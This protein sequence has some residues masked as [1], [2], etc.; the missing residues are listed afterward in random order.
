MKKELKVGVTELHGIA[1]ESVKSPPEGISY[2]KLEPKDV[3]SNHI[4]RS[5]AKGVLNRYIDDDVDFVEAPLF[6]ILTSKPWIYTPADTASAMA[7]NIFGVP[8]PRIFRALI[9]R[10]L[11]SRKNFLGLFFKSEAGLK[12]LDEYPLL[13]SKKIRADV[14]YPAVQEYSRSNG[15]QRRDAS[16]INLIFVGEFFRKGGKEVIDAFV[17]LK[18]KY[19]NISLS[20]CADRDKH[21]QSELY[22]EKYLEII[23]S[24]ENINLQ[25]VTREE[26]FDEHFE[27]ADIFLCPTFQESFG[28]AI[29]EAM[30]KGL[31]I[32]ASDVF[33]IPEM[34][35][36]NVTGLLLPLNDQA[37]IKSLTGY[38]IDEIPADFS[39]FLKSKLI[40]SISLLVDDEQLRQNLGSNARK[41]ASEKFSF[42]IRNDF[43]STIYR[44]DE[45]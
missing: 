4:F 27:N 7:F 21:F 31:P 6:P 38:C 41:K 8:T 3:W 2:Q 12:T 26:L 29:L 43:L 1:Q 9:L 44:K 34:I 32:I 25:F 37:Y 18:Q 30:A 22:K 15:S 28:Y 45:T 20:I 14:L 16:T 5:P 42:K 24:D 23:D 36:N 19:P 10:Y 17:E 35:E 13:K 40:D 39:D 33:A 11:F